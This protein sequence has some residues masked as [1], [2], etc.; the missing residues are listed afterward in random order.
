MF[1]RFRV[2]VLV[3][4]WIVA[5]GMQ[6]IDP[7][8][9]IKRVEP[10]YPEAARQARIQGVVTVEATIGAD[11]KVKSAKV[12]GSV[13]QLDDAA[14]TAVR[15]WEY[16]PTMVNGVATPV[17][18]TVKVNFALSPAAPASATTAPATTPAPA[19]ATNAP[20]SKEWEQLFQ[21]SAKLVL[22][23]KTGEA[24]AAVERFAARNPNHG[25]AQYELGRLYEYRSLSSGPNE[26]AKRRD[27]EA[28]AKHY[29]RA[30]DL[31]SDPS[32]RFLILWK[33]YQI[34]EPDQLNDSAQAGRYAQQ[35]VTEF[36]SRAESHMV[37]AMWLRGKGD[38]AGAAD[39]I[40][41]GRASTTLPMAG[42]LLSM[43]YPIEQ[44]QGSR[45]LSRET[46]RALLDEAIAAAEVIIKQPDREQ[47]DY[48]VATMAKSMALELQAERLT[49]T[50]QQRLALLTEA[51][52]WSAPIEQ[53]KNLTAPPPR[54]L[55]ATETADLE[56]TAI[57]RWNS[58]LAD[59]GKIPDA[60]DGYT[61]YLAERPGFYGAYA[62][63]AELSLKTAKEAKDDRLRTASL[64][65][66]AASLQQVVDLAP[67][68]GEREDAFAKLLEV[69]GP[70]QLKR[71]AQ[72]ETVARAMVKRQPA[73]PV[74]HVALATVLLENGKTA[75]ADAA[76]RTAHSALKPGAEARAALASKLLYTVRIHEDLSPAAGRRL[77]D[78]ADAL[79]TEAEK[80]NAN[81]VTVLEGRMSWLNVSA[82][83]F[84][85]DPA[86]A[87]AQRE[88][89]KQLAT[90]AIAIRT[91][92]GR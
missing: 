62:E 90:R 15:Q 53:H 12:V 37:Y 51:A 81:E 83:R 39:A 57:R 79:L 64:E 4:T 36:P 91:K 74:G 77:F 5:S 20:A 30:A 89:A 27:E 59:D 14:L 73:A 69:Y 25:E 35:L 9:Q 82:D 60:I 63:I 86:R 10:A 85:K 71:A 38:I 84:E 41:K 52:R 61:K 67:T 76:L 42:L 87:A 19:A 70:A 31:L 46:V 16:A 68:Q 58:R 18:M 26:A 48:R 40:R 21:T 24:I 17:V 34:Y 22:D 7:P 72:Q 92:G 78:E 47:R 50:R 6:K 8:K 3:A 45:D 54:K 75:D 23:N 66:A 1:R 65:R 44:V 80:L 32:Y 28:A 56:W 33:L 43:Q 29:V 88:R 2:A 11:G 55:T 49:Q 13:P